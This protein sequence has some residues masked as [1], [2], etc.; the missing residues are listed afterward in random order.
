MMTEMAK[1]QTDSVVSS[2]ESMLADAGRIQTRC[3][4]RSEQLSA[5]ALELHEET[6]SLREQCQASQ[7]DMAH[8]RRTL[9]EL[10]DTKHA[11]EARERQTRKLSKQL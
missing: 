3:R 7:L 8:L 9:D 2:V 11:Y 1:A 6:Q 5:A 4:E 10:L